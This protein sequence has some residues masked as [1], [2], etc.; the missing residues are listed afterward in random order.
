TPQGVEYGYVFKNCKL[1]A[2]PEL[3]AVYLGRPWR[4]YAKTVFLECEMGKHILPQGWD[5]WSNEEAEK[6]SF[7]AEYRNSG[8]GF[9]PQKRV[10]WS[11]QLKKSEAKNYTKANILSDSAIG[12]K[13]WYLK[14]Y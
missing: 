13:E 14:H 8:P 6:E 12:K 1:T 11:H 9:Q 7:Y 4:T 3:D 2:E 10:N 5:N